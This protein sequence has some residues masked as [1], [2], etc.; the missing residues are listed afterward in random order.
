MTPKKKKPHLTKEWTYFVGKKQIGK[1]VLIALDLSR[2]D[3]WFGLIHNYDGE[4]HKCYFGIP[5][6]VLTVYVYDSSVPQW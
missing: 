2:K 6:V 1:K 3:F 5:F 4:K